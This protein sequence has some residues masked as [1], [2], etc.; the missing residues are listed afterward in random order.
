VWVPPS[1]RE[2]PADVGV[3]AH[4]NVEVFIP[5]HSPAGMAPAPPTAT[6]AP[7]GAGGG[8]APQ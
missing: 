8:T 7:A 3:R 4:T 5:K 1:S 6:G 2:N